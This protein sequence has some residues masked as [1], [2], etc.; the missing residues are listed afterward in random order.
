MLCGEL[1]YRSVASVYRQVVFGY[2]RVKHCVVFLNNTVY[3]TG[4]EATS[5]LRAVIDIAESPASTGRILANF[6]EC[7]VPDESEYDA[8]QASYNEWELIMIW[9]GVGFVCSALCS[10]VTCTFF[11]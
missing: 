7:T 5:Q 2:G 8:Y 3:D 10:A 6:S 1:I 9:I 4:S 11:C